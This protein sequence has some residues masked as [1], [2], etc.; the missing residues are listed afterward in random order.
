VAPQAPGLEHERRPVR[1]QRP[2]K[3]LQT[4]L[5]RR[6]ATLLP[7][8]AQTRADDVL[9]R[10]RPALRARNHVVEVQLAPGKGSAAIL[11]G[12]AVASVDVEAA[13]PHM[14]LRHAIVRDEQDY[15]RHAHGSVDE[16]DRVAVHRSRQRSPALEVEGLVLLVHRASDPLIQQRASAPDRSDVDR[17]VG[18]VEN[19]YLGVQCA[20][21]LE[22]NLRRISI[23]R[24]ANGGSSGSQGTSGR[25]C[26]ADDALRCA[27]QPS[28]LY[29]SAF[30]KPAVD[31]PGAFPATA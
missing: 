25:S 15:P 13:E 21:C 27:L 1:P 17:Q 16:A 26:S 5:F 7:I 10:R 4:R 20:R 19:Q 12:V 14:P 28:P 23:L 29:F 9:P 18:P 3:Q 31:R 6:A 24:D 22:G 30:E 8:A 11:A 2:A